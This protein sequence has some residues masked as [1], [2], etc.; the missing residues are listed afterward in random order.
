[1]RP[2]KT[3]ASFHRRPWELWYSGLFH[4]WHNLGWSKRPL[5]S[6]TMYSS[7]WADHKD[8]PQHHDR[9]VLKDPNADEQHVYGNPGKL[10]QLRPVVAPAA[11]SV[12]PSSDLVSFAT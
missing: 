12:S 11:T 1:M 6:R 10:G 8:L 4:Y 3:G 7:G 2:G 9:K 5:S